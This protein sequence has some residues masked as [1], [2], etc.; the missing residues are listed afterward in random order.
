MTSPN[1]SGYK[2]ST[3]RQSYHDTDNSLPF[4]SGPMED[5]L[6]NEDILEHRL[7]AGSQDEDDEARRIGEEAE[8][9]KEEDEKKRLA[10]E[11]AK[12]GEEEERARVNGSGD[13]N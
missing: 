13:E 5:F 4:T 8:R 2:L 7:L 11:E 6:N 1:N 3:A 12:K 10:D 9:Q